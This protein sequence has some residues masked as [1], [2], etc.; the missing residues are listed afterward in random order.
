M[1]V[2]LRTEV[3]LSFVFGGTSSVLMGAKSPGCVTEGQ[4]LS[5]LLLSVS[6]RS[7]IS[8][9][10]YRGVD[11]RTF[12]VILYRLLICMVVFIQF[13]SKDMSVFSRYLGITGVAYVVCIHRCLKAITWI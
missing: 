10:F 8:C 5:S 1:F 3:S 7:K 4:N 2:L 13:N 9:P 12:S 6:L 11:V